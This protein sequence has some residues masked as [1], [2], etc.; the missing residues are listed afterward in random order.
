M[1]KLESDYSAMSSFASPVVF[2]FV[3]FILFNDRK[4][5]SILCM[6]EKESGRVFE[7]F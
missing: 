7:I 3:C 1:R 5:E 4:Y 2:L 6:D